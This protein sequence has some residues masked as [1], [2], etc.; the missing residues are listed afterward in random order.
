MPVAPPR[1]APPLRATAPHQNHIPATDL[2]NRLPARL[3]RP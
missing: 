2:G 1:D 3:R